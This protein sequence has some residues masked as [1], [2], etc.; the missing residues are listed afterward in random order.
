MVFTSGADAAFRETDSYR[1]Y[2]A[3]NKMPGYESSSDNAPSRE[4]KINQ[5]GKYR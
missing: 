2:A 4:K 1:K 3:Y 5:R